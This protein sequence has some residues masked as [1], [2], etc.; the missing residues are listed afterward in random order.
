MLLT[1]PLGAN[2][3][4]ANPCQFAGKQKHL[5]IAGGAGLE[6]AGDPDNMVSA[7]TR[8]EYTVWAQTV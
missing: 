7:R 5:C 8:V 2:S 1:P 3:D 6:P 4:P